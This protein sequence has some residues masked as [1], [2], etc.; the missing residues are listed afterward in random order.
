MLTIASA[1]SL[2]HWLLLAIIS[3]LAIAACYYVTLQRKYARKMRMVLSALSLAF[4]L[5]I[6]VPTI[7]AALSTPIYEWNNLQ[8]SER[9]SNSQSTSQ[10][11][12]NYIANFVVGML[13]R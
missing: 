11:V 4:V 6:N 5:S 12:L 8:V 1:I 10:A 9:S 13:N 2:S 7:S 3:V